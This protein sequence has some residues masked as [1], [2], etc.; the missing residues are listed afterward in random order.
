[1]T[2]EQTPPADAPEEPQGKPIIQY[3]DFCKLDLRVGRIVEV[4]DHPNADRLI[5]LQV[6]LGTEKRQLVAGI[7][8][9]Y[10]PEALLGR[11][12]VVVMNLAPRKMRGVE[13]CGMLLA[14]SADDEKSDVVLLTTEKPVPPGATCS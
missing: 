2:E 13:S 6:D 8:A 10:S 4:S 11:D 7:K 3:D 9:Y 14:A 5:V 1:M 12:I